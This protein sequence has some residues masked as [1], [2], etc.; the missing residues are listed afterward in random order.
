MHTVDGVAAVFEWDKSRPL[1]MGILNVTPDSFF[2][3]GMFFDADCAVE[4]ARAMVAAG[5][6]IVDVG[7]ESTRPGATPV[8]VEEEMRRVVPVVER[9]CA[10]RGVLGKRFW[11][12]VDTTK[13]AVAER[14]L[15]A[16]AEI[17]N[18]VS[19]LRFDE[20]MV[21]VVREAG[22]AVVLMHMQGTPRTMQVA[23]RYKDVVGDVLEFL[24]GRISFAEAHGIKKSQ[25]AIDPGIG[26]GKT[27]E[28]NLVLLRHLEAFRSLG[29]VVLVGASRK[30]FIGKTLGR[31]PQQRLAG[32][33]AVAVWALLHGAQV[34]RVHDVAETVDAVRMIEALRH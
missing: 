24:A 28:H 23:P 26:F 13:A 33:L 1:V 15:A 5:A 9:V 20:R 30:S 29:C 8:S 16:G 12:S 10:L 31:E 18:D 17:V 22:A 7:G 27:V 11:V 3:G 25:I 34:L 21:E 14:A 2:D 19:A 6:D 32:S 4:H